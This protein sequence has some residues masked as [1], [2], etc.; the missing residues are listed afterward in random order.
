MCNLYADEITCGWKAHVHC[1]HGL[2]N[3]ESQIYKDN[4]VKGVEIV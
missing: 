2:R 3:I 1:D 4:K